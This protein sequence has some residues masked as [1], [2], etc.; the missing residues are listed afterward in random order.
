MRVLP[1]VHAAYAALDFQQLDTVASLKSV[2]T[3]VQTVAGQL[4]LGLALGQ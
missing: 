1:S 2:A 4:V 3:I